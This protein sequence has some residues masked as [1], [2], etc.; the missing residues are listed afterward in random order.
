MKNNPELWQK[1]DILI[2]LNNGQKVIFRNI[3]SVSYFRCSENICLNKEDF[4]LVSREG[5]K[6]KIGDKLRF[7]LQGDT[8]DYEVIGFEAGS[9]TGKPNYIIDSDYVEYP[10]AEST[11]MKGKR[12]IGES[13]LSLISENSSEKSRQKQIEAAWNGKSGKECNIQSRP[14]ISNSKYVNYCTYSPSWNWERFDFRINP[15]FIENPLDDQNESHILNP[16]CEIPLDNQ[17]F[18]TQTENF[19]KQFPNLKE[20]KMKTFMNFA[21]TNLFKRP[22]YRFPK[23][24]FSY[25]IGRQ[26]KT[27]A[28]PVEVVQRWLVF[29]SVLAAVVGS[30]GYTA[31]DFDRV[32][33]YVQSKMPTVSVEWREKDI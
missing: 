7:S 12:I 4:E 1:G 21:V 19:F 17:Y 15:N 10:H 6:Y 27:V 2:N 8:G 24:L 16:C 30:V 5:Y 13:Y 26:M 22:F 33:N 28:K 3:S 23:F 20:S 11:K 29:T 9:R 31:Y 32:S 25:Y 18:E 14:K